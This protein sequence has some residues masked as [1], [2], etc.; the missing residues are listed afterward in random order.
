MKPAPVFV[1]KKFN[2]RKNS[3]FNL[4]AAIILI[5][6]LFGTLTPLILHTKETISQGLGRVLALVASNEQTETVQPL[7]KSFEDRLRQELDPTFFEVKEFRSVDDFSLAAISNQN[8]EAIFSSREDLKKQ[9]SS[10]QT[11]LVKSRIESKPIK[12]VD[13]RFNKLVVEY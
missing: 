10:L 6:V 11:L 5:L 1:T 13:L 4:V 2:K 9:V 3:F 12:K 7:E 8:I